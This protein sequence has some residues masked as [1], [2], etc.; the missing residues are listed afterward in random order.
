MHRYKIRGAL[1]A[2]GLAIAAASDAEAATIMVEAKGQV[3]NTSFNA[4]VFG[5]RSFQTGTLV[6]DPVTALPLELNDG[7]EIEFSITLDGA[8]GVPGAGEQFFGVNFNGNED[9]A[10]AGASVTGMM[11]FQ[12]ASGLPANPVSFGCGNCLSAIYF[13]GNAGPF[14]FTALSG[15]TAVTLAVPYSVNQ[16]SISYQ[17]SNPVPEPAV[18]A[19][20]ISGFGLA[21]M[22]L[23]RHRV[24]YSPAPGHI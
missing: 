5:G 11:T 9:Q 1:A 24:K 6:L 15:S 16:L 19:L 13:G 22:G 12:G 23:R 21:G 7:D 8:F 14:S 3:A 18:W 4:F 20:M 10:A 2:L 17:I